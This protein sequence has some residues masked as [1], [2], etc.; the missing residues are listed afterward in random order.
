MGTQHRSQECSG[1]D[2]R[3]QFQTCLL[4]VT[5]T[6]EQEAAPGYRLEFIRS[7]AAIT[8]RYVILEADRP[9]L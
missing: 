6:L 4:C 7:S 9:D 8:A 5:T 1:V 3:L 2:E